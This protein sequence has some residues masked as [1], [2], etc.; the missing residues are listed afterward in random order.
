M[1]ENQVL[2]NRYGQPELLI[3]EGDRLVDFHGQSAGFI[4]GTSVYNYSGRHVGW[5][6]SGILRDHYGNVVGFTQNATD[7][8]GP[9]L[10]IPNIPPI[11]SIPSIEPIRPIESIPP[12]EPIKT[13]NW[14]DDTPITLINSSYA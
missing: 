9:I 3:I 13:F 4:S 10:P 14:S 6:E 5:F 1:D 11:P 7:S 12:I 2:Y 8:P